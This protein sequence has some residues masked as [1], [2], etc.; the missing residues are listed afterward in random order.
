[1]AAKASPYAHLPGGR[2]F[3]QRHP[4]FSG[5]ASKTLLHESIVEYI[6]HLQELGQSALM[7]QWRMVFVITVG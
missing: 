6:V 7:Y 2:G 3:H 1:M 4:F 5:Y